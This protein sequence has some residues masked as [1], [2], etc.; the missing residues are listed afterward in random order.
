VT[1][2]P[3]PDP[4]SPRPAAGG[5]DRGRERAVDWDAEEESAEARRGPSRLDGRSRRRW[6]VVGTVAVVLM[7]ALAVWFGLEATTGRVH[8]TNTGHVIVSGSQVDVRFD[9]SREPSR[10][11]TCRL[12][13]QDAAHAVVGR[14][15][16]TVSPSQASPSRHVES[17]RTAAPAVTGYVAQC[18]YADEA[19]RG[20]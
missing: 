2:A 18:W 3:P 1:S 14:A 10:E 7:S 16:V 5:D 9:L 12:E 6:W 11:V 13:A 4:S 19:P 17:V 8:W 15:D 20:R